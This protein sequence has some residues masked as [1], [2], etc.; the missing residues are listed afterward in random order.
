MPGGSASA[1]HRAPAADWCMVLPCQRKVLSVPLS[2]T[3]RREI[4]QGQ[5]APAALTCRFRFPACI[6]I[7][8]NP[9]LREHRCER[10][11]ASDARWGSPG[12]QRTGHDAFR[13]VVIRP[14]G[15]QRPRRSAA[16]F[17]LS[18]RGRS[19][20]ACR[21]SATRNIALNQNVRPAPIGRVGARRQDRAAAAAPGAAFPPAATV[22]RGLRRVGT[23]HAPLQQ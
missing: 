20:P 23:D 3:A 13:Q 21:R 2:L 7:A 1:R 18:A 16:R 5:S 10:A 4:L 8:A 12:A 22:L 9:A 15:G 14:C 11:E 19:E 17:T 6:L